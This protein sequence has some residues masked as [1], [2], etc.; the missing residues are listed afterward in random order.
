[1]TP[2]IPAFIARWNGVAGGAERANHPLFVTELCDALGLPRPGVA[3]GGTL[4]DYQFEGPVPQGSAGGGTGF[5]D[6]Y[7]RG[8]FILEAKQSKLAPPDRAHPELFDA[9]PSAPA[10]PAG[11][12]Y[13]QL[14]R[15]ARR[16]AERYARSL[17]G[18]H[19]PV[20]FLIVCDVG[21]A[22]EL[23]FDYAGNGRGYGFFP[24]KNRY[25]IALADLAGSDKLPGVDRTPADLLRAIWLD[26]ASVD[27]RARSADVTRDVARKLA[28]VSLHLEEEG[29]REL[30]RR[31]QADPAHEAELVEGTALFLMRVLFCMFAEDVGL[32]PPGRFT[33]FLQSCALPYDPEHP[34]R[35]IDEGGL[36][37]G[38]V[39]LWEKMGLPDLADRYAWP[40]REPVRWFNGGLFETRAVYRLARNDLD[41]LIDAARH[42][43]TNVEPA[44]FGTLLEQALSPADR[45][46]LGAHYTPR[47]YVERLVQATITDVL[48]PEWEACQDEV[49]RLRAGG[50]APAALAR[51][52]GFLQ[53]LQRQRVLDPACGT[54]NF[55]YV[56]MEALLR[57][58]ADVIEL[59]AALGGEAAPAIGPENFLGLELNPRAAVIAELVMWIGWLRWR[60]ANDPAAVPDPVLRRTGAINRGGRHGYDA[61]LAR[62]EAGEVAHPPA[63]APWPEAEFIVGNPPFIGKGAAMRGALG[64]A[65]VEALWKANPTVPASADFVMFWWDRA[66]ALL[67]APDTPLRRFGFVTTNSITGS[68]NRRVVARH[69]NSSS[70]SPSGASGRSGPRPDLNS[71]GDCLPDAGSE[72]S[73]AAKG[74]GADQDAAL[75]SSSTPPVPPHSVTPALSRGPASSQA[76]ESSGTPDQGTQQSTVLLGS[77]VRGDEEEQASAN[78]ARPLSLVFAVPDHPWTKAGKDAAAVRIAMTACAPGAHEGRLVRVTAE[79]DLASD[80]PRLTVE[81][82]RGRINADL[83]I[84]SDVTRTQALLANAGIAHDGVKLHGR[85]FAIDRALAVMLGLGNR[86]GLERYVRPYRNGKD[87]T[88]RNPVEV[89]DKYIIDF[90]GLDEKEVRSRYPE[91]Y[92]HLLATV[93]VAREEQFRKSPTNDA[94]AYLETWWLL[95][96]PRPEMRPA[97]DGLERYI[98]TVDTAKHRV[99]Q[100][101]DADVVCDDKLVVI[102]DY[103]A[104]TL[105]VLSSALH[106]GWSTRVGGWLGVGNDSVYVKSRT[107]DPF[108]FP[109][110]TPARR[111][112][113]AELAE[114]LDA[115]RRAALAEHP[116]LTMTGLYNLV[117]KLRAGAPLAAAQEE[118]ARDARARIV[119]HLHAQLDRAVAD[120]YAW[121]H[122]LPPAEIVA[123]LVHLNA[124]RAAEEASG[125]IRWLRPDYQLPRLATKPKRRG[126]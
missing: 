69:L 126:R 57:L 41:S 22:F 52:R 72:P 117:D 113:V 98:A 79:R 125:T 116:R 11:A 110:P 44:I 61:V 78:P 26:P 64:D 82:T 92:Q 104:Y 43:W 88:Q 10:T 97:L 95:G 20:P 7:K 18:D 39:A 23:H 59:V 38:L 47:P 29:R 50:D 76:A 30:K 60:T 75:P 66:A 54:A 2:D 28:Q 34:D 119:L 112:A 5:I 123:R 35:L 103:Q 48:A 27:P 63:P 45:A 120:A 62:D 68:F 101:I 1:M 8:C 13:D 80:A 109:D 16:Q 70:P 36:Q 6:L 25:R 24:D 77:Q 19:P 114:E 121:P 106:V 73:K 53:H 91:A 99:F 105:G 49:D 83:T 108:P 102:A 46:K 107:F 65:Y 74:G 85:G 12:R 94:R 67:A 32:L 42:R 55:L 4:S 93:R 40:I 96:K 100:F 56:A 111:A 89:A 51:A 9:A 115:T 14:M 122:D 124:E 58:E 17:P 3:A 71:P 81:A 15:D 86:P 84:G 90:Y 37:S 118:A 21:R 87:L 31:G 33:E